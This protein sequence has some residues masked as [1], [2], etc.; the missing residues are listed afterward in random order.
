[1]CTKKFGVCCCPFFIMSLCQ[2]ISH[3][4]SSLAARVFVKLVMNSEH[5][6]MFRIPKES[7]SNFLKSQKVYQHLHSGGREGLGGDI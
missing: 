7:E 5:K 1:M 3:P 2:S 6:F 4:V